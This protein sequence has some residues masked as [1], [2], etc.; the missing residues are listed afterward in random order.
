MGAT[1]ELDR[2]LSLPF[3]EGEQLVNAMAAALEGGGS[4]AEK[5]CGAGAV[6][7]LTQLALEEKQPFAAALDAARAGTPSLVKEA[8]ADA[9]SVDRLSRALF[10]TLLRTTEP[11]AASTFSRLG[12]VAQSLWGGG[13]VKLRSGTEVALREVEQV[14]RG[15]GS[16]GEALLARWIAGSFAGFTFFGDAAFG[17]SIASGLDLMVLAAAVAAFLARAHAA[18][19]GRSQVIGEDARAAVRQVDA[20]LAHRS[21]MPPSFA[22]ALEATASLDLLREQL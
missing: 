15:L 5:L 18:A 14:K 4:L 8:L 17:L 12:Q 3:A 22:R 1:V 21:S 13:S 20:G 6:C 2:G 19:A 10:R 9:P 7:A 11:G 16:D